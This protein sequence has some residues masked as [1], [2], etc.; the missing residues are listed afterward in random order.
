MEKVNNTELANSLRLNNQNKNL[1]GLIDPSIS[2][3]T[4]RECKAHKDVITH[5]EFIDLDDFKGL[6]TCSNDLKVRNWNL[7]LDLT[8]SISVNSEK[9]DKSWAFK[10]RVFTDQR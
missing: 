9:L 2:A 7:E 4:I 3:M 6:L 5:L 8:G 10:S 1:P